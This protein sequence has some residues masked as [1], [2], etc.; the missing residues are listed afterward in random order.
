MSPQRVFQLERPVLGLRTRLAVEQ[1]SR[2][3]CL[4]A[5]RAG[6]IQVADRS[7]PSC[8]REVDCQH[9]LQRPAMLG[10]LLMNSRIPVSVVFPE[11]LTAIRA[12]DLD[13]TR[14]TLGEANGDIDSW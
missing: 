12:R 1:L 7:C 5:Y 3:L 8:A 9:Q 6:S 14:D 2:H 4:A 11:F 13:P 10:P